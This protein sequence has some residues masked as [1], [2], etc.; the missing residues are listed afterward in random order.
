[1]YQTLP[2]VFRVLGGTGYVTEDQLL[3]GAVEC[4]DVTICI[5]EHRKYFTGCISENQKLEPFRMYC[6]FVT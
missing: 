1:M 3:K 5:A 2:D 4:S 6:V